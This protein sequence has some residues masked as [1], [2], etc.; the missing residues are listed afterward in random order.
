M[1][2]SPNSTDDNITGGFLE[3]FFLCYYFADFTV[4]PLTD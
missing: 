3:D 1:H 4:N 2:I